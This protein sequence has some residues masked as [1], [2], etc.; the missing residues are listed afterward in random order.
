[1]LINVEVELELDALRDDPRFPAVQRQLA[2]AERL[3]PA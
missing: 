3:A 2:G 1:V